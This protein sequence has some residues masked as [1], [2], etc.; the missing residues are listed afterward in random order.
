MCGEAAGDKKLLPL[1]LGMG[2]D[3]LSM[4]SGSIL[5]ARHQIRNTNR[6]EIIPHIQTILDL[7]TAVDVENYIDTNILK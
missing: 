4:S 2:L 5:R 3:E 7:P 1:L 6:Q